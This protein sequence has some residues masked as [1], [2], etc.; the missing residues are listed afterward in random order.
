MIKCEFENNSQTNL[1]HAVVGA[2]VVNKTRDQVLLIRRSPTMT[3]GAN[4]IAIPG[5]FLDTGETTKEGVLRELREET[6][7]EAQIIALFRIK[8]N[9]DRRNEDRQNIDFVFL[10]EVGAKVGEPDHETAEM[11]WYPLNELPP[12]EDW[13]F[14]HLFDIELYKQYL[15]KPFPLPYLGKK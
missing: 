2:I 4:L 5:G 7:Y 11:K 9:P 8:D 3:T 10:A 15:Q 1:R 14:D 13:A 6:G 12:L